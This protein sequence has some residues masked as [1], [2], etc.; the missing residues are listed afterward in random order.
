MC[1]IMTCDLGIIKQEATLTFNLVEL[2]W[3][4]YQYMYHPVQT[5]TPMATFY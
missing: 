5:P 2:A 1:R 3:A 4:V